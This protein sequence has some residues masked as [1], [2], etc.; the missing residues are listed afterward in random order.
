MIDWSRVEDLK[1][2]IGA[3]D[4]LEVVGMFLE[5]VDEVIGRLTRGRSPETL[6]HDLHFLK[7]SSLNLGFSDFARLCS[8]GE[9][10]AAVDH[11]V[12]LAPILASYAASR[13]AFHAGLAPP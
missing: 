1:A 6:E 13:A 12:D 4:F 3:E 5:E 10:D 2:D 11:P 7:S 8:E 9:R